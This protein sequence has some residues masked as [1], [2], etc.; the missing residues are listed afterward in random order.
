M[1]P[2]LILS[3]LTALSLTGTSFAEEKPFDI[4]VYGATGGGV[5]AAVEAG[6][7]GRSVALIEP[8][9]Y[10]GG[11]TAG[12]LGATDI[13]SK[14]S[15]TGLAKEFYHRVWK[16]YNDPS[17]WKYE[18]RAEYKPKHHDA[19]SDNLEVHWFFEPK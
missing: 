11:M 6:R 7:L 16:H 9:K 13:G 18:T 1:K 4:V 2:T 17:A 3:L 10:I 15:I 5:A 8:Q 12:G 14:T 19:I